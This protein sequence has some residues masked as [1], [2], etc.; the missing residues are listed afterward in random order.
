AQ[1]EGIA[2]LPWSPL[3]GGLLSGKYDADKPAG[4]EGSRRTTFDFPPVDRGR[5]PRVLEALRTVSAATGLSVARIA[6]AWH[7]TRPF[8]TSVIIAAR[9]R[10]QPL[11]TP[12]AADV[13]L[14]P[15]HTK[16]LDEAS[17]LPAESP[18]WMLEFQN[19]E[20]RGVPAK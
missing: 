20:P 5:L 18:G 15:E 13:T 6:L 11:D 2:I 1:S 10:A 4:P 16:L 7:L 19:R 8:L 3:A 9:T 12:A 14:S 17:A